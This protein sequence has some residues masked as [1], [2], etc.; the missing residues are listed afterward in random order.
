MTGL[1]GW[2]DPGWSEIA[3]E[4]AANRPPSPPPPPPGPLD[5]LIERSLQDAGAAFEPST[6]A[7]LAKL[8]AGNRAEYEVLRAAL[9]AAGVR[10][11]ELDKVVEQTAH[12]IQR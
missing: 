11:A 6:V 10:V 9:K 1:D 7:A 8:R 3:Q 5:D 4:Y 12:A 2:D